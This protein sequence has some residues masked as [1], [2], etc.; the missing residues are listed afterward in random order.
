[1]ILEDA[2]MKLMEDVWGYA[3]EYVGVGKVSPK[4]VVNRPE[5]FVI[6]QI[7]ALAALVL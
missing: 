7:W 6:E 4:W 3:S 2:F 5:A 1:M